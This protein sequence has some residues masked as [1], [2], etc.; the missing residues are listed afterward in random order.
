MSSVLSALKGFP[1]FVWDVAKVW[2]HGG[3]G[4]LA[5]GVTFWILITV[6]AAVLALVSSASFLDTIVGTSL[7]REIQF[8]VL[9]F[10]NET[11]AEGATTARDAVNNLFAQPQT[12]VFTI[13]AGL[14]LFTIS[15]GF[16][17][18]IRALDTVYDIENGRAW[19]HTR[20]V[21]LILGLGTVLVMVPIVLLEV[22]FWSRFD[23]PVEGVVSAGV[24]MVL[25]VGWASLL[26]HYGP[27]ARSKWRWDLPGALVAAVFW[28]ALSLGFNRY[29]GLVTL[30]GDGSSVL[31]IIGG[32]L[33]ALTWIWL[34][35]Q[36]LLIG[37]AVNFVL[38]ER[39]DLH[40]GRRPSVINTALS[41]ATGELKKVVVNSGRSSEGTAEFSPKAVAQRLR[42][43]S[44]ARSVLDLRDT[45]TPEPTVEMDLREPSSS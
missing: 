7:K 40:R 5:A 3:I 12:G 15:R 38:G 20:F 9:E 14:T 39:L 43:T 35:A 18:M 23:V 37:A 26:F 10:V 22:L 8:E 30:G 34:A 44:R 36:V 29:V 4:D 1:R 25:L 16:A 45:K 13:A 21:G 42:P 28:W 2:Y 24:S 27:S 19:Y 6:P 33:L 31:G 11:F 32:F 41:N 17:G